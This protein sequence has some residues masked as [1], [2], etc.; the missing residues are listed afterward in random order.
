MGRARG[1]NVIDHPGYERP[2]PVKVAQIVDGYG[3]DIACERWSWLTADSLRGIAKEGREVLRGKVGERPV[4]WK[5][6]TTP[7]Q[8]QAIMVAATEAGKIA[9]VGAAFGVSDSLVRTLFRERGLPYPKMSVEARNA[10]AHATRRA[11]E[12][13]RNWSP[14]VLEQ[15][16]R[17]TQSSGSNVVSMPI[18]IR[19]TL[20]PSVAAKPVAP[21]IRKGTWGVQRKVPPDHVIR[22]DHASGMTQSQMCAKYGVKGIDYHLKRLGLSKSRPVVAQPAPVVAAAPVEATPA[23]A[24]VAP[25]SPVPVAQRPVPAPLPE[26]EDL[27]LM[28]LAARIV[29]GAG[30]DAP[31]A[32]S[33]VR[34]WRS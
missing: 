8:E 34:A 20:P 17:H 31:T 30:C 29:S 12:P 14:R 11:R 4:H 25:P 18:S 7:E 10:K 28:I 22:A 21:T 6:Q 15:I 5:R 3:L 13:G 23:P 2:D 16:A 27:D 26:V 32:I 1:Q 24:P 9:G 19:G 33:I